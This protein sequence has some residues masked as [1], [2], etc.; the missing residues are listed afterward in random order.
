M[1]PD[2]MHPHSPLEQTATPL[3]VCHW[4]ICQSCICRAGEQ[5]MRCGGALLVLAIAAQRTGTD[6]QGPCAAPVVA[7]AAIAMSLHIRRPISV[8]CLCHV[9]TFEMLQHRPPHRQPHIMTTTPGSA[10][11][12]C[13]PSNTD[14]LCGCH[15]RDTAP[16]ARRGR[17]SSQVMLHDAQ[18]QHGNSRNTLLLVCSSTKLAAAAQ[19]LAAC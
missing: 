4:T 7:G 2:H 6:I 18:Q 5:P 19:L 12:Q 10:P 3:P 14:M 15:H 1:T 13:L 9:S 17:P 16:V 11:Y 8:G